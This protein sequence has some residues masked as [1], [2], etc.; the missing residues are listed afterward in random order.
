M[1]YVA[2]SEQLP[3]L[4]SKAAKEYRRCSIRIEQH[5][6]G[7]HPRE[8]LDII[9]PENTPL[10]LAVFVHGGYWMRFDKSFWTHLAEGARSNGWAVCLPSYTLAPEARISTMTRQIGAAI[11]HAATNVAGPITLAGH[12]A[13]GHLICRMLCE[14]T[15]LSPDVYNRIEHGLSISGVHDLRPLLHT[16]MN[17][18]LGLDMGQATRESPVLQRPKG[19]PDLTLWVGSSTITLPS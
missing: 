7:D 3:E 9:W 8:C 6:Y 19:N 13:G 1:A 12:S 5:S 18:I 15:P 14:D 11:S 10:G 17:G 4:W 16:S 2:G